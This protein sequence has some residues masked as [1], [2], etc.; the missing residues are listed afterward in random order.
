[1][2]NRSDLTLKMLFFIRVVHFNG[3]ESGDV[4]AKVSMCRVNMDKLWRGAFYCEISEVNGFTGVTWTVTIRLAPYCEVRF[5]FQEKVYMFT[6][7]TDPKSENLKT[8]LSP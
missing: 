7:K 8:L 2:K 6:E 4:E 5:R 3:W 1:M